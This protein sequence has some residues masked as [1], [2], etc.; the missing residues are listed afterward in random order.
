M[1]A[2]M[3]LFVL[4]A[5]VICVFEIRGS[6]LDEKYTEDIIDKAREKYEV[7]AISVSIMDA[8]L[9]KYTVF[10]GVREYRKSDMITQEDYFHLGSCSKSILAYIAARMMEEG[11]IRWDTG[12][13]DIYP[14]M[15]AD[16]NKS[17]SEITLEDL[18][19]CRAGIQ[20]YISSAEN[21]PDLSESQ[22]REHDF[23]KYLLMQQAVA[24]KKDSGKFGFLYSNAGY[25]MAAAMLEKASGL[26]YEELIQKYIIQELGLDVFV[27]W[28]YEKS[29]D[30]PRGH[31]PGMDKALLI[32]GPES[33]YALNPLINPAGNL[34]MKSGDF[35]KFVQ[36]HMQGLLGQ[37]MQLDSETIQYMDTKYSEF[38]LGVWNG[39]RTGRSYICMDGTAGTFFARGAII[40]ESDFGFS[41]MMNSGSEEA[42]EYIS[43]KLMKAYYNQWWMFWI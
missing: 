43:S 41:I 20:P 16:A 27:G 38:S 21:Y 13:F 26:S 24:E 36:L 22:D 32:I 9:I 5:V 12:F 7:P 23:I 29:Q 40:P 18:L 31:L 6:Y 39:T 25:T 30:Q 19:A 34:S 8:D 35:A 10:D 42:V 33:A 14:E 37:D 11:S 28:P 4:L 1:I 3:L 15:K 17:Y 2:V